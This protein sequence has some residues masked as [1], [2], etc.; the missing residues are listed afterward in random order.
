M[1]I[2]APLLVAAAVLLQYTAPNGRLIY[3]AQSEIIAI[4]DPATCENKNGARVM[5]SMGS[6]CIRESVEQAVAKY[7]TEPAK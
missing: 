4:S 6:F 5:T 2:I 1:K 7:L 3:F